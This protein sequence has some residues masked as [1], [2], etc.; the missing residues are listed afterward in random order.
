MNLGHANEGSTEYGDQSG[1][2]VSCES[3]DWSLM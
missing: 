1:M 2:M 3:L